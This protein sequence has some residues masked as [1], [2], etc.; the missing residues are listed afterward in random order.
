V[1][2]GILVV[3]WGYGCRL[4]DVVEVRWWADLALDSA[5]AGRKR[6]IGHVVKTGRGYRDVWPIGRRAPCRGCSESARRVKLITFD[7]LFV[8]RDD[9]PR[10][11][12][13]REVGISAIISTE[14]ISGATVP[15]V[16]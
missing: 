1:A 4:G 7:S 12:D 16:R 5:R 6:L 14:T 3:G 11:N 10:A 8:S 9:L 13:L 15:D 2:H